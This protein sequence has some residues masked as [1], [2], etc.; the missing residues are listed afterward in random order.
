MIIKFKVE[1]VTYLSGRVA[2]KVFRNSHQNRDTCTLISTRSSRE[3][4]D[5]LI[6]QCIDQYEVSSVTI[7]SKEYDT[8]AR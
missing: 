6:E 5:R 2:Y 1:E 8:N 3:E 7:Y 4:A